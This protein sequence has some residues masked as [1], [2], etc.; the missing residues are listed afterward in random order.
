MSVEIRKLIPK[1]INSKRRKAS[2]TKKSVNKEGKRYHNIM[3]I[4]LKLYL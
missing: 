4:R 3:N 2:T 1:D